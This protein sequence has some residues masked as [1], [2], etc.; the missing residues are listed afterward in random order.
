M[1]TLPSYVTISFEGFMEVR[2]SVVLR[3]EME[4]GPP[5]QA[6]ISTRPMVT[7]PVRLIIDSK[8][9]YINFISWYSTDLSEGS[10]WFDFVDPVSNSTKQ[11]R[12]VSGDLKGVPVNPHLA[13]WEVITNIETWG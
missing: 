11:A 7:R 6:R 5:K 12:F 1:P 3:T 4:S 10:S 2:G 9:N 13:D 8:A